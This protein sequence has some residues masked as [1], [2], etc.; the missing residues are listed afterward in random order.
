MIAAIVPARW[1]PILSA[2]LIALSTGVAFADCQ[3]DMGKLMAK[4]QGMLEQL[5]KLTNGGKAKLDPVAACPKL[6]SLVSVENEVVAYLEK[7][8]D[9]C[10]VPDNF[11]DN[12]KAG[13]AKDS[14]FA[15]K[16]CQFAAQVAKMKQ[17]QAEGGG[18]QVQKLPAGPL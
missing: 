16:A 11:L 6:K 2:G 1:L 9:W 17:Q 18:P 13:R 3:E 5:N 10:N 7:N 8:K 15:A 14:G 4:R 12:A